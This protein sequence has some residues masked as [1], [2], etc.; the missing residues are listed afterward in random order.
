[1][2]L[3]M[4]KT[5]K[6]IREVRRDPSQFVG[7]QSRDIVRGVLL[8]WK[9]LGLCVLGVLFMFGFTHVLSGPYGWVRALFFVWFIVFAITLFIFKRIASFVGKTSEGVTRSVLEQR[10]KIS[11]K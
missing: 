11:E 2:I 9:L 8:V 6:D 10:E 1:M 5:L 3:K 4:F 7:E